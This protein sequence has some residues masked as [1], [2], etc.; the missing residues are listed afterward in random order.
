VL[1]IKTMFDHGALFHKDKKAGNGSAAK[2]FLRLKAE[3][4]CNLSQSS[5]WFSAPRSSSMRFS[6][7]TCRVSSSS[8]RECDALR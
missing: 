3:N 4:L 1:D 5:G 2:T 7:S 8:Q 6:S